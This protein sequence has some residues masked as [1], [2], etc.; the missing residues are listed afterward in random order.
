MS[1]QLKRD[2]WRYLD[3]VRSSDQG[4]SAQTL[5]ELAADN[6]AL[7][8]DEAREVYREWMRVEA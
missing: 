2:V 3:D 8:D 7:T 1:E 6:F 4:I 5:I